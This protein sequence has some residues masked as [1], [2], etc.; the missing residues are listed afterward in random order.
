LC[1]VFGKAE[2]ARVTPGM[3]NGALISATGVPCC[4]PVLSPIDRIC[5]PYP[6]NGMK[7]AAV[8]NGGSARV[9]PDLVHHSASPS[10]DVVGAA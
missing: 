2:V 4:Q 6:G 9:L 7:P 3:A 8:Q 10:I 5:A 1:Y